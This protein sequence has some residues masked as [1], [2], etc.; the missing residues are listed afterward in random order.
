M[1]ADNCAAAASPQLGRERLA[2]TLGMLGSAHDGEIV[3]AARQAERL[4]RQAGLT[5]AEIVW[6]RVLP[7]PEPSPDDGGADEAVAFCLSR[8]FALTRWERDF[9]KSLA[10]QRRRQ[11]TPKQ[12]AVIVR[13]VDK[14]WRWRT[15]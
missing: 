3:A 14:C 12:A 10:A 6:P 7:E 2:K 15:W 11:L 9:V 13:L 1:S 8:I 5:W 4:R